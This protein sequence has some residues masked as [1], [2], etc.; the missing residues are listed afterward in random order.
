[1]TQRRR[2]S[3]SGLVRTCG[4]ALAA[5]SCLAGVSGCAVGPN[6]KPPQMP[7]PAGWTGQTA[8]PATVEL[9][10]EPADL[11]RWWTMFQDPM[12]SSLVARALTSNLGLKQAET[13]IREAQAARGIAFSG[14]GPSLSGTAAFTRAGARAGLVRATNNS[15]QAALDASWELDVI[16][17]LRRNL[18]AADADLQAIV[19]ARRNTEVTLAAEVALSYIDVRT[20]QERVRIARENLTTQQHNAEL[21]RSRFSAGF[22]SALDVAN[23][24]AQVATTA[25]VIA[26]LESSLTQSI[27]ALGVLLGQEPAALLEELSPTAA[28]PSAPPSVPVGVPSELL[29]RRP[30]IRQA[31]AQIHGATA[32]IGVAEADLFPR[33]TISGAFGFQSARFSGWFDSLNGFWSFGPGV[34]WQLFSTGRVLSN[35]ELAKA[36]TEESLL[37]YQQTVL[38]ALQQVENALVIATKEEERHKALADAVAANRKALDLATQLYTQGQTDFLNVLQAQGALFATEDALV[39]STRTL[40][41]NLVALYQALG[42]GW[43]EEPETATSAQEAL[44]PAGEKR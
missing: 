5:C 20:F 38:T 10:T 44:S 34:S 27:Y 3:F 28:V 25:S 7:V 13:R 17:G 33:F 42:G 8:A 22:V 18:E 32:R 21:T 43:S 16:G 31:E 12:L 35:I 39:E 19:E 9:T 30:D 23:A 24:E 1:M 15:Y 4:I 6:Y 14:L 40:S 41:A 11:A 36:L 2:V 26:A 29:R 37:A